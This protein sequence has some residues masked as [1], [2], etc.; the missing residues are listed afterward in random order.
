MSPRA[1][2][3]LPSGLDFSW[4]FIRLDVYDLICRIATC[5][6][7]LPG[8]GPH[9]YPREFFEKEMF[10]MDHVLAMREWQVRNPWMLFR[11]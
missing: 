8:W 6:R 2:R 7:V 5:F 3:E 11:A 1:L 10:F 4:I 9:A